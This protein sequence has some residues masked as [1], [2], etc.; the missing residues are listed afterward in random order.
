MINLKLKERILWK[1]A[2]KDKEIDF[3]S[4]ENLLGKNLPINNHLLETPKFFE[5]LADIDRDTLLSIPFKILRMKIVRQI[6][7]KEPTGS[8][9]RNIEFKALTHNG[10]VVK[11]YIPFFLKDMVSKLIP[12]M[13]NRNLI[14][15][16]LK[17]FYKIGENETFSGFL[18]DPTLSGFITIPKE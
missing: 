13:V 11:F 1:E 10:K 5:S 3:P 7:V 17:V 16:R 14:I 9:L 15:N 18:W 8:I 6:E 4:D 12:E 2:K